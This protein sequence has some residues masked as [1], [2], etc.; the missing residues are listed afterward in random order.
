MLRTRD[1][2]VQREEEALDAP[3]LAALAWVLGYAERISS[4]GGQGRSEGAPLQAGAVHDEPVSLAG[5]A[6]PDVQQATQDLRALVAAYPWPSGEAWAVIMCELSGNPAAY[7][8]GNYGA[9]QINAV[10]AGR[11]A[12]DLAS[13]FD[14]TVNVRVAYEIWADQGWGPWACRP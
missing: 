6:V 3:D 2:V 11:V 4:A 9:F 14:P 13:L 12:G 7:N 10:H 5:R 8:M 1:A